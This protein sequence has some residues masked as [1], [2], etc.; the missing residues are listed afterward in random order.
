[1]FLLASFSGDRMLSGS[2][3]LMGNLDAAEKV[4]GAAKLYELQ[5]DLS[6]AYGVAER[7]NYP[8]EQES[9]LVYPSA[10]TCSSPSARRFPSGSM[11][12]A[13][14]TTPRCAPSPS[15]SLHA[16]WEYCPAPPG[17]GPAT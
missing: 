6:T 17:P 7:E 16:T 3:I 11:S 14:P 4:E 15:Y 1:M 9:G 12:G 13:N 5:G 2:R 10:V 8:P